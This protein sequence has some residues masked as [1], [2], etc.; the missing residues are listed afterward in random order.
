MMTS[1]EAA[2]AAFLA[3]YVANELKTFRRC[4]VQ[5]DQCTYSYQLDVASI[6]VNVDHQE[7]NIKSFSQQLCTNSN[8]LIQSIDPLTTSSDEFTIKFNI[9]A[10]ENFFIRSSRLIQTQKTGHWKKILLIDLFILIIIAIC[11]FFFF[12]HKHDASSIWTK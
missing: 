12:F 1:D 9:Y 10:A 6:Y 2:I 5:F 3:N 11:Y 8:G 4:Y 7:L